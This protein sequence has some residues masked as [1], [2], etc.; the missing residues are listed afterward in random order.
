MFFSIFVQNKKFFSCLNFDKKCIN[1]T[2][3]CVVISLQP[4]IILTLRT[5]TTDI[6]KQD[7]NSVRNE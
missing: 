3:Q 2:E 7:L 4:S 1:A 6:K 5:T